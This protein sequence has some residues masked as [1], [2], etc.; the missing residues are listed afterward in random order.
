MFRTDGSTHYSGVLN[1]LETI[2]VMQKLNILSE[3]TTRLGGTRHKADWEDRGVS[4]SAK[5]KSCWGK[6]SFD[7]IN[8]TRLGKSDSDKVK[9]FLRNVHEL[10]CKVV[11]NE[12]NTAVVKTARSLFSDTSRELLDE[13]T[14]DNLSDFLSEHLVGPN[15]SMQCVITESSKR[16]LY[17]FPVSN[18][19]AVRLLE[20]G[21]TP[22]LS[23]SAK[24][25]RKIT[26]CKGSD[27]VE[28]GLR[29][30]L[31][32]NNGVKALLGLATDKEGRKKHSSLVAKLQQDN[33]KQLVEK[34]DAEVYFYA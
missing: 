7:W 26:F 27:E 15:R 34:S 4:Y 16:K 28:S 18:H 6:G 5:H 22:K 33:I 8:T 10:S 12:A 13:W 1:E 11:P 23:G 9:N 19:P 3:E 17:I 14:S 31:T 30:R 32:L 24:G 21:Y 20:Q 2:R 25:S 29:L